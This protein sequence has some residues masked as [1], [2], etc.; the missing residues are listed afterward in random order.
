[1]LAHKTN[2]F[3][4]PRA[5]LNLFGLCRGE[6]TTVETNVFD[7]SSAETACEMI[8][9]IAAPETPRRQMPTRNTSRN[10]LTMVVRIRT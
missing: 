8:V 1:M 5:E 9:A 3:V 10:T 4:K 2:V 6:K 7:K